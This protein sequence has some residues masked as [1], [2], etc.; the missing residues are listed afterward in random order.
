MDLNRTVFDAT[1][2]ARVLYAYERVTG[3]LGALVAAVR[4]KDLSLPA[5]CGGW[6]VRE[7]LD[8]M[9]WEN[10]M[11]ASI[12]EDAPRTD[13]TG[14]HLGADHIAAFEDSVRQAHAAFRDSG[15]LHRTYGPYA[16]PGAMIVQQVVV[17]LLAHGGD[18]ARAIGAPTDLAP[19]VA[20]ET[21][22]AA[23]RIH[24]AVP[25]TE[26]G[27]FGPERPVPPGAGAADRLA[28]YLGRDPG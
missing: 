19:E 21:L 17:E 16:A 24:G 27:S 10:L 3:A 1:D 25:R 14:D 4:P 28:A 26:G 7:L 12:A 22:A 13:H 9:V 18:L 8:H 5:P 6:R 20:E 11:A 2:P 23:H 15:M